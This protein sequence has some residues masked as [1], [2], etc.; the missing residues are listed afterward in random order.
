M[1]EPLGGNLFARILSPRLHIELERPSERANL[2]G[3]PV[4]CTFLV[5]FA[6]K[7]FIF[8]PVNHGRHSNQRGR[9]T[10]GTARPR[11]PL[12]KSIAFVNEALHAQM[13]D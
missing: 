11:K 7:A 2:F 12:T 5:M 8:G 3:R 6:L 9:H 10:D 4:Y 13:G 1:F